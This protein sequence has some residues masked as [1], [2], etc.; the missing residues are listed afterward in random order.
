M[1][2]MVSLKKV[3]LKLYEDF[4]QKKATN[5][6]HDIKYTLWLTTGEVDWLLQ[7]IVFKGALMWDC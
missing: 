4:M 3:L 5:T 1:L 6:E 7:G 2:L